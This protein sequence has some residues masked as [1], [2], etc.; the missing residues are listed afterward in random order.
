MDV[1]YWLFTNSQRVF[2]KGKDFL[3]EFKA[4]I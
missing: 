2:S 1:K 4:K 3:F